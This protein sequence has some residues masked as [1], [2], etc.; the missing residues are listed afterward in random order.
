MYRYDEDNQAAEE[1]AYQRQ[2]E[3]RD[4]VMNTPDSAL[5]GIDLCLK[6]GHRFRKRWFKKAW[7]CKRCGYP[8]NENEK[9]LKDA[10]KI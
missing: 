7:V 5:K 2:Q 10:G 8:M 3:W 1:E 6:R 4:R 9:A